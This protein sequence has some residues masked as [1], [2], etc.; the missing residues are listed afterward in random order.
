MSQQQDLLG[1]PADADERQ[2]LADRI[3]SGDEAV[4]EDKWAPLLAELLQVLEARYVRRGI[5]AREAFDLA[6]DS[7][8]E[9]AEHLGGRVA[10][11]PRGDRIR[12]A[13]RDAEIYRRCNGKNQEDLGIEYGL[14]TIHIYRI[15]RQQRELNVG[16]RQR[17]LAF[18]EEDRT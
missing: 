12:L 8:L 2:A 6:R 10:Y 17:R 4:S 5:G 18:T 15:Y 14:T 7:V 3:G 11:L 13:L 16:R 1:L 9:I